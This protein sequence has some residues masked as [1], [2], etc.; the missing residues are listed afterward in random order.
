MMGASYAHY[1]LD[2]ATLDQGKT[3]EQLVQK[4][5]FKRCDFFV[6]ELEVFLGYKLLGTDY[7]A[8]PELQ[9]HGLPNVKAPATH[10]VAAKGSRAAELMPKLN[11]ALEDLIKSGAAAAMWKKHA[12]DLPYSLS[13]APR[14]QPGR[15]WFGGGFPRM[16]R[17][18]P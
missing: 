1:G 11:A 4:L 3:H 17:A 18:A 9:H 10:V 5:K 8:D 16:L 12:G 7:L 6:E 15:P 2:G 13:R 14:E